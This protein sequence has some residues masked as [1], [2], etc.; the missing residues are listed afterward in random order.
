MPI[1]NYNFNKLFCSLYKKYFNK[2]VNHYIDI[3][4]IFDK[5]GDIKDQPV[6][7]IGGYPDFTQEDPRDERDAVLNNKFSYP[8]ESFGEISVEAQ[9]FINKCMIND[10]NER[11]S[12]EEALNHPWLNN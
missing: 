9:D 8:E 11:M 10:P 7:S 2:D 4:D 6:G 1:S 5:L 3:D 12:A